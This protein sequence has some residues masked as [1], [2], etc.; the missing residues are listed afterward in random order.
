MVLSQTFHILCL[1]SS[2]FGAKSKSLHLFLLS[3][4]CWIQPIVP[5]DSV[6]GY[7]IN[8]C[9][10]LEFK[11]WS[12]GTIADANAQ[13]ASIKNKFLRKTFFLQIYIDGL[14]ISNL[15]QLINLL[16]LCDLVYIS[17]H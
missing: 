5:D 17:L 10:F 8:P 7:I 11:I 1:N 16:G 12:P 4:L 3:S 9:S 15:K 6:L 14:F 13:Q 2:F